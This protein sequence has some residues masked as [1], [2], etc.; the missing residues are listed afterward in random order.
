MPDPASN[1]GIAS[2]STATSTTRGAPDLTTPKTPQTQPDF[3]NAVAAMGAYPQ[4]L[5]RLGLVVDLL[6]PLAG[7]NLPQNDPTLWFSIQPS[8]TSSSSGAGPHII[9]QTR[10]ILTASDFFTAPNAAD[11]GDG[12]LPGEIEAGMVNMT[13]ISDFG[14]SQIDIDGAASK[15][16]HFVNT[17]GTVAF[18][19]TS[20]SA[21][22]LA[23]PALRTGGIQVV[24]H[25][26]GQVMQDR[27]N[28][29]A[30]NNP[31][32]GQNYLLFYLHAEDITRGYRV[33]IFDVQ[34]NK[35]FSLMARDGTYS[36][37]GATKSSNKSFT[38]SDE[39]YMSQSVASDNT[40]QN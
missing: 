1:C 35:W 30:L 24:R 37:P 14:L 11:Y 16:V 20:T 23:L 29:N 33:D 13:G 19:G 27:L 22:T 38:L 7:A 36:V 17:A 2:S 34:A 39:G 6:V 15:L 3:H 26:H 32:K 25:G 28:T 10:Y 9:A 31:S 40:K 4:L 21:T 5:R 18:N 8:W 12:T